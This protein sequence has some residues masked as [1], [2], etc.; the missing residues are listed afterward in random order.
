M[1]RATDAFL[2]KARSF[3]SRAEELT[4][5]GKWPDEA[6]R[7]AYLATFHAAQA[8]LVELEGRRFKT[9]LPCMAPLQP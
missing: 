2:R 9:H 7:M 3:I 8:M 1:K 6:G 4:K 5:A